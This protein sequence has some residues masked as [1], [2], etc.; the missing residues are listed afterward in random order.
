MVSVEK[1]A[2]AMVVARISACFGS[3]PQFLLASRLKRKEG[4]VVRAKHFSWLRPRSLIGA[5]ILGA[6]LVLVLYTVP[7]SSNQTLTTPTSIKLAPTVFETVRGQ[8]SNT[9]LEALSRLEMTEWNSEPESA[10]KEFY[11][12]GDGYEGL[13]TYKLPGGVTSADVVAIRVHVNYRGPVRAVQRWW[14]ELRHFQNNT[15]VE[16]G[17]NTGAERWRWTNRVID[18]PIPPAYS[19]NA[20][21]EILIRYQT[22]GNA[23]ASAIDYLMVELVATTA[24]SGSSSVF[25]PL[26][27][28]VSSSTTP[29]PLA[30]PTTVQ[31]PTTSPTPVT[32]PVPPPAGGVCAFNSTNGIVFASSMERSNWYQLANRGNSASVLAPYLPNRVYKTYP[33]DYVSAVNNPVRRGNWAQQFQNVAGTHEPLYSFKFALPR[34]DVYYWRFYRQYEAGYQFTCESKAFVVSAHNPITFTLPAGQ[35]PDGT[36][37]ASCFL[38]IMPNCWYD[39]S[40]GTRRCFDPENVN[41]RGEPV[42]YCYH[43]DQPTGYGE[44]LRQNIGTPTYIAGGQWNDFQIMMKLNTPGQANG[45]VKLWINGELKLYYNTI[46]FRTIPELQLNAASMPGY[47]GG[48]CT[49][50]RDQKIWDDHYMISKVY[51]TDEMFNAMCETKTEWF[52]TGVPYLWDLERQCWP[53]VNC[54]SP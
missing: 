47:I 33:S 26:V 42:L 53:G 38:Q 9:P 15:W 32:T 27:Q 39:N 30:S 37:E 36:N 51:I 41:N 10:Y 1:Q 18:S 43:L 45:E 35:Y 49:S 44:K 50:I 4:I 24:S 40:A 28:H 2:V 22:D 25:I 12:I 8:H 34:S 5:C 31:T 20:N 16:L 46:R 17:D 14:W 54:P 3:Y 19:I 11:P 21:G 6:V 48:H 13:F 29:T 52:D 7:V 23:E